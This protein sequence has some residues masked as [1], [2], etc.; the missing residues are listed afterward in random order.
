MSG[1]LKVLTLNLWG[2]Q[3]PLERRM[4]LV[5][6][7]L[8][9]LAPDVVALQEVREVQG[10]LGNQAETLARQAGYQHVFAP[11]VAWGG[12][13]EGLA[14]MARHPIAEHTVLELPHSHAQERRVLLSGRIET[15][16]GAV[17]VHTTH[18]NYRLHHGRQREDQVVALEAAVA[19]RETETPQIIM[20]DFN[21]R[22]ESDEIRWMSGLTTLAERR[23]HYQDAWARLHP[24]EAGWTWAAANPYTAMLQF[25]EPDRRI[26]YVF[27]TARRRDGRGTVHGCR[28]VLDQPASDGAYASDHY[29][30]F[31]E[32]QIAP[33]GS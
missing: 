21:A 20:G 30:V 17:W 5:I 19:S 31:A 24:G 28:L 1:R 6:E 10:K 29:G 32:V 2:E 26:D 27:V 25:L 22:P 11:T 16:A 9:E 4:S 8:A 33:G 15:P 12:G 13:H 18:L 3:P 7:G 14:L 23:V